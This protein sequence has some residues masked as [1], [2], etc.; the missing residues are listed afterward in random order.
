MA[1]GQ[2]EPPPRV[3]SLRFALGFSSALLL[4]A[5]GVLGASPFEGHDETH[6]TGPSPAPDA[7]RCDAVG[8]ARAALSVA[9]R[10]LVGAPAGYQPD[11]ALAARITEL[12]RSQEQ[13][14]QAAW[15]IAKRVLTPV[16]LSEAVPFAPATLPAWQSWHDEEDLTRIF[17]HL[18]P[19]LSSSERA[20]RAPF[21]DAAIDEAWR[22]ND[23][24]IADFESWTVARWEAYRAAIDERSELAGIAGIRRVAYAPAASRHFIESYPEL[25]GCAD[26]N[27]SD[28]PELFAN[29]ASGCEAASAAPACL[30]ATFPR[31]ST[32]V[33]ADWRRTG[34]GTPLPTFDTSASALGRRLSAGG[35]FSWA[36]PDGEADPGEDQIYTLKLPNGNV[37]RLAGLHIMTKELDHWFW[38]TLWWSPDPDSDFGADRPDAVPAPFGNYKLCS[39]VDFIENDPDPTG[40]FAASQPSLGAAL[41]RTHSGVGGPSWCSNPYI[42]RGDGNAMTNCIGCHQ[43]AGTGLT[44]LE[45]LADGAQFPEFGRA[46]VRDDFP[47]DYV[48]DAAAGDDL[49]AMFEETEDHYRTG[50]V[51]E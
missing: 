50:D 3:Q 30:S 16:P 11:L 31:A 28:H 44:P 27:S 1:G 9:D 13:R 15:S 33:K 18:Y 2:L 10:A 32:L 40:G 37:Y 6:L 12:A 41:A 36:E 34:I 21:S 5:C 35:S 4:E 25:L 43:H 47:S 26:E 51:A 45:I 7:A 42:E 20:A 29:P 24:A 46:L 14:R 17:R 48:F 39:V 23:G 19:E 49:R 22:W 8:R 38:L